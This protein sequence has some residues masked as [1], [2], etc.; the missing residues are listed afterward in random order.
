[1]GKSTLIVTTLCAFLVFTLLSNSIVCLAAPQLSVTILLDK[2]TYNLNEVVTISGK[3]TDPLGNAVV[4]ASVSILISDYAGKS[5]HIS[6]VYTRI[7]GIYQDQFTIPSTANVGTCT[8]QV[9]ASKV[10]YDNGQHQA[11]C[12]LIPEFQD[13][14]LLLT[15]CLGI[16]LL[17]LKKPKRGHSFS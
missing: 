11:T 5:L 12:T 4:D 1:V 9:T 16:A 7:D 14:M 8:V 17:T 13:T 15:I 2:Q 10:G 6:R 3:V